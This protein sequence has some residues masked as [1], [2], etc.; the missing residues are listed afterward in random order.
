MRVCSVPGPV[1]SRTTAERAKA[2]IE[3]LC[4]KACV[5]GCGDCGEGKDWSSCT[6]PLLTLAWMCR[7]E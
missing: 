3:S 4:S 7:S 5:D 1:P 6:D 2:A